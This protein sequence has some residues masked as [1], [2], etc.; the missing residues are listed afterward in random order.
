MLDATGKLPAGIMHG[1]SSDIGA[2][3]ECLRTVVYDQFGLEKVRG[4]YCNLYM[5]PGNDTS[6][7]E[8]MMPAILMTHRRVGVLA[9]QHLA[10][11]K[12]ILWE[13]LWEIRQRNN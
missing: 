1:T 12:H 9:G 5:K 10:L 6:V 2:F 7:E 8:Y 4:Q 13:V 3:D 11:P